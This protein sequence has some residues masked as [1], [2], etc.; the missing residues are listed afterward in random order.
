MRKSIVVLVIFFASTI[1]VAAN[2]DPLNDIQISTQEAVFELDHLSG[3][4]LA[5]KFKR[6]AFCAGAGETRANLAAADE[7]ADLIGSN[8]FTPG[9]HD[10][11]LQL[12]NEIDRTIDYCSGRVPPWSNQ[13][14]SDD[15]MKVEFNQYK[16]YF[17]PKLKTLDQR[18]K[19]A[20]RSN[21]L[22]QQHVNS[23]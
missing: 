12:V 11:I 20:V 21:E 16:A 10:M 19:S 7:V 17:F 1:A 22:V 2:Y 4:N 23:R 5:D 8:T 3:Q 18:I 13:L 6:S 15:A 14:I 9:E